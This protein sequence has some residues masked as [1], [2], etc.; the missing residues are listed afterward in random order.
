MIACVDGRI[1]VDGRSAPLGDRADRALFHALRARADAVMAG[2]GTVRTERYGPLIRDAGARERRRDEGLEDQPLAVIVTRTLD[3]DAGL[4]LL[5]DPG[6]RVAILTSAAG[7]IAPAA[8]RVDYIRAATLRA[9][10]AEL[11]ERFGVEHVV[12]EG[13]PSLNGALATEGLIEELFLAVSPMLV[14][15]VADGSAVVRGGAPPSPVHLEL[16]MLL[17]SGSGLYGRYVASS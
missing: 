5:A 2:A 15:D 9:G 4:P 7:D 17:G 12:C 1:A 6:S 11:R 8:A 3:L 14:G 16:R 13:G 10:L